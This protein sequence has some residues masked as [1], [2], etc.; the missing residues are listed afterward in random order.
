MNIEFNY[1][2]ENN[3]STGRKINK[4]MT[5]TRSLSPTFYGIIDNL[6]NE[7]MRAVD[8]EFLTIKTFVKVIQSAHKPG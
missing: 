4:R 5:L 2:K 3:L 7:Y 6:Y 8:F 1:Q